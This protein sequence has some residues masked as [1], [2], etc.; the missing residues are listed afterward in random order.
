MKN[1]FISLFVLLGLLVGF[2]AAAQTCAVTGWATQNGGT[3]GG[4]TATPTVVSNYTDFKNAVTN[5][6]V[7]VVHISGTITFPAAGRISFQDQTGKTIYGLPGSR[8]VTSDRT[9]SGSGAMYIKRCSN[10]IFKNVTFEGPGAYDTDGNDNMT[11]DN[12]T[13]VWVDH[14]DFQDG[15]DGNLDI[16]N[17]ADYIS[18]T[19]CRFVYLKPPIAGGSGGADDHRF[20]NLFGSSDGA[21]SDRGKL[22]VTMQNCWWAQGC[23]ERMPRVRFGKVHIV[24]SYFSCAGN[25]HCVRAGFESDLRVESNYFENVNNP[26]DLFENDFTAVSSL[27][28]VFVGTTG[29]TAGSGTAFTPPYS[30]TITPAANVKAQ[31]TSATCGAGATLS[32]PTSCCGGG[33]TP[34]SYTLTTSASPAAGGTITRSPNASS[35]ATG[36]VV[37]LTAVPAA[38]YVFAGWSGAASGSSA[39]TS[40][41]V[42]A[43]ST[44]TATFTPSTATTYTLTTTA[45]PT[46]G[47]TITRSPNASS[48]AAGT[49]VTLTAVPAAGY[50]FSGWSGA[51][52]ATT[53]TTTVTVNANS[54]AT[55][56]FTAT[57]GGGTT[58]LRIED[59]AAFGNGYCD[60]EGSRQ[61]S[62]TGADN[63]YY[64][65][66]SNSVA[67]GI[68]WRVS[69]PATGTYTLR[70]RYANASSSSATSA[71]VLVNGATAVSSVPFPKT[72]SWTTWTTT[73]A[74]V[75]LAAGANAIRL[76]TIV[77]NEFANIDWIEIVG[78]SPTAASCG[79]A[80]ATAAASE[81]MQTAENRAE[82][83]TQPLAALRL[84]PNP[85]APNSVFTFEL[86][87]KSPVTVRLVDAMG[88]LVKTLPERTYEAGS[89]S[90]ALGNAGLKPGTYTLLVVSNE[91]KQTLRVEVR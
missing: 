28:N 1:S 8:L 23:K 5:A 35:Y 61:S 42:T 27:N 81:G 78:N 25:N 60:I 16:K 30:L 56:N 26:I 31:V 65:N 2:S 34:T 86:A 11:I 89:H 38:G 21:T 39:T 59:A 15:V 79:A 73:T 46:A 50:A 32:S 19:W 58:T 74:S 90:V 82:K 10:I 24:N 4:G 41:T 36:T 84:Y 70:W 62:Y 17:Q 14:C 52:T 18:V 63:G 7:K 87:A 72:S 66:I 69:V 57:S 83:A 75:A 68:D 76:E 29:N 47:G 55:A 12:C 80:R 48:Y 77:G 37:T 54:T 9:A 64:V 88:L 71:K 22:R 91:G 49:V 45:S 33:T 3:T 20:S 40:V 6:A 44:A 43:N 53:A 51:S 85:A 13:N 67:R